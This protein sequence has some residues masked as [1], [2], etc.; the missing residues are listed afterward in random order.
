[1]AQIPSFSPPGNIRQEVGN[2]TI[3][4]KYERPQARGR[5]IYGGLVPWGKLW[6]TG[7]G[8]CTKIRFSK[9]VTVGEQP[10]PSGLYSLLTIPGKDE[11]MV[12]L[13]TDTTLYRGDK[14]D[15]KKD[16]A[17]FRVR[18]TTTS[19]HY[20]ALTFDIELEGENARLYISWTDTQLSFPIAT[21]TEAETMAYI[22][23]LFTRPLSDTLNY[24]YAAEYLFFGRKDLQKALKLTELGLQAGKGGYVHRMRMELFEYLGHKDKAL[25][26][27][28]AAVKFRKANPLDA[29]NQAWD[30]R[31]WDNHEQRLLHSLE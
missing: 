5:V 21:S 16:V 8:A 11:W 29:E 18:P 3:E 1:M 14:H 12:I 15:R 24:T 2:A 27:V 19:R 13:N 30:L 4:L 7:A 20:E 25:E 23:G 26:E 6:R 28:R 31:E 22:D 17:R 10:V 9:P